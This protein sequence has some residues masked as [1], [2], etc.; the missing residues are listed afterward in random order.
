VPWTFLAQMSLLV[1]VAT[2]LSGLYPAYRA[3]RMHASEQV[4]EE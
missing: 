1:L 4:A 2:A 3:S